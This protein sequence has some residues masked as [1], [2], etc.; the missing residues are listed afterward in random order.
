MNIGD[1][2]MDCEDGRLGIVVSGVFDFRPS[3]KDKYPAVSVRTPHGRS[4]H[5]EGI[6]VWQLKDIEIVSR[7]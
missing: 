1:L 5:D 4:P 6:W 2:V 3:W 7:A